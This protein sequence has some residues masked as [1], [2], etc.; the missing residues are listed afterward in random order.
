MT[1][2][3]NIAR[4]LR[5]MEVPVACCGVAGATEADRRADTADMV[6]PARGGGSAPARRAA[7]DLADMGTAKLPWESNL[8]VNWS[9]RTHPPAR[10]G[11]PPTRVARAGPVESA[12]LPTR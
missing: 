12:S 8:A 7:L 4:R 9:T 10:G 1:A 3:M 11:A 2:A 6:R 5:T